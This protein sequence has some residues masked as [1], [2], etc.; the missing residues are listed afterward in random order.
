MS[1]ED[2]LEEEAHKL[3]D[4]ALENIPHDYLIMGTGPNVRSVRDFVY[5]YEDGYIVTG[6]ADYYPLEY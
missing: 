1:L 5:A 6:L 4:A 3:V 2:Q